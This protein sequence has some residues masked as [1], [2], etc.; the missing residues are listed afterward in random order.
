MSFSLINFIL[1][2]GLLINSMMSSLLPEFI[3]SKANRIVEMIKE[4]DDEY[5][6][7]VD[8][9]KFKL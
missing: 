4:C 6:P 8:L 2:S 9:I 5:F 7:K 3:S 1:P